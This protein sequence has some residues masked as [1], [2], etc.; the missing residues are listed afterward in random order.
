MEHA[1]SI[2]QPRIWALCVSIKTAP[3]IK[4]DIQVMPERLKETSHVTE[5]KLLVQRVQM[6]KGE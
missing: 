1:D 6:R 4:A 3:D 2:F 5:S